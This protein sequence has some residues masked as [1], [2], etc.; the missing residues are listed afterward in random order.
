MWTIIPDT[1]FWIYCIQWKIDIIREI[2]RICPPNSKII[3]LTCIKIE[4]E[5]LSKEKK[6]GKFA[7]IAL[8]LAKTFEEVRTDGSLPADEVLVG[9]SKEKNSVIATQDQELKKQI[10][11][12]VLIIRQK[13][14]IELKQ[15][16]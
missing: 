5:K 3:V 12:T 11:S 9:K 4:L 1:N 10:H 8:A 16:V 2:E 15:S 13:K 14:Y 7:K 6:V